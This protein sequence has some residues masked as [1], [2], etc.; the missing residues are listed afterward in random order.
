MEYTSDSLNWRDALKDR[1]GWMSIKVLSPMH[2][3]FVAHTD[4]AM[5]M[6]R[7]LK[8]KREAEQYDEV[9]LHMKKIIQQDLRLIDLADFVIFNLEVAKPTFG[10]L[11]ELVVASMQKKPIFLIINHPDGKRATPLWLLGLIKHQYIYN[12]L[13]EVISIL[14]KINSGE[15]TID[16]DRWR[17]LLPELR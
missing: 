12:S 15:K 13:E 9:A 5:D 14:Q 11:H 17:L 8:I 3:N 10:T 4:E 6:H 2:V 7:Q 16:S 1:L